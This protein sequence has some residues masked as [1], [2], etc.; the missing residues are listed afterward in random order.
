MSQVVAYRFGSC[1]VDVQRRIVTVASQERRV[2]SKVFDLLVA[3]IENRHRMVTREELARVGWRNG[4]VS[5]VALS[6]AVTRCRQAIDD[7]NDVEPRIQVCWGQGYRFTAEVHL[8]Y[9]YPVAIPAPPAVPAVATGMPQLAMLPSVRAST[10]RADAIT[11][12]LDGQLALALANEGQVD[13]CPAERV[14]E[15]V[16]DIPADDPLAQ[17]R[18]L[19]S[20]LGSVTVLSVELI[21]TLPR[22]S[23]RALL[24][25]PDGSIH[26]G[27]EAHGADAA[28]LARSLVSS[29]HRL[30]PSCAQLHA[31]L[32]LPDAFTAQA[33]LRASGAADE[34]RWHRAQRL[35]LVVC[36]Q[37]PESLGAQMLLLRTL[38]H[39]R[40]EAAVEVGERLLKLVGH[41]VAPE[42]LARV[43]IALGQSLDWRADAESHRRALAHL[44]SA[45]DLAQAK[46]AA[47]WAVRAHLA[48][49]TRKMLGD[50]RGREQ[51]ALLLEQAATMADG[52]GNAFMASAARSSLGYLLHHD[53]HI[54]RSLRLHEAA[55]QEALDRRL[56]G[57]AAF[58]LGMKGEFVRAW[59]QL[60]AAQRWLDLA[61]QNLE[62]VAPDDRVQPA[63]YLAYVQ[64]A[65]SLDR[66]C[67]ESLKQAL[68]RAPRLHDCPP[69][70]RVHLAIALA[71]EAFVG[72]R[73][74]ECQGLLARAL[75]D[76]EAHGLPQMVCPPAVMWVQLAMAMNDRLAVEHG[77]DRLEALG[78]T[79]QRVATRAEA[80]R[81]RAWLAVQDGDL[82][83]AARLLAEP[84]AGA[85]ESCYVYLARLDAAWIALR[86]G[87]PEQ[88]GRL[89][90]GA[91]HWAE[92][93]CAGQ[94]TA[95]AHG[96]A[97]GR[98][99]EARACLARARPLWHGRWPCIWTAPEQLVADLGNRLPTHALLGLLAQSGDS[100]SSV[101]DRAA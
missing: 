91:A 4:L 48:L 100:L 24:F 30:L 36:D 9:A 44:Q 82:H 8:L 59:G 3:L 17:L 23:G 16:R 33:Y 52:C 15:L 74:T 76:A 1:E 84:A 97:Q 43:H 58:A 45:V 56:D 95:M 81:A 70:H 85:H 69:R 47:M 87:A 66:G 54:E 68:A 41:R 86:L 79:Q 49:A 29:F 11:A 5:P 64:T 96:L 57:P 60:A 13:L 21:G 80:S 61:W 55:L 94:L 71:R 90:Q 67:V 88:A 65:L 89:L 18:H 40:T 12:S 77:A 27:L 50:V 92:Q 78:N 22:W 7:D 73:W 63:A 62:R 26:R 28:G 46:P 6:R 2:G 101:A 98:A 35:A 25:G 75:D 99:V 19:W 39:T 53:G 34:W 38:L 51:A 37:A 93:S 83:R 10:G 32:D 20:H 31:P 14:R 72:G 42:Y